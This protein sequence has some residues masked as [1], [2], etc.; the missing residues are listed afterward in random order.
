[1][2]RIL[3]TCVL[4]GA[5]ALAQTTAAGPGGQAAPATQNSKMPVLPPGAPQPVNVP[6]DQLPPDAVVVTIHG[7]CPERTGTGPAVSD[8][9]STKI[10]KEQ[11]NRMLGAINFEGRMLNR[12]TTRSYVENYVQLMV[13]AAVAEEVGVDKDPAFQELMKVVRT[14][15]LAESYRRALHARFKDP[16]PQDFENYYQQNLDKFTRLQIDRV[17]IPRSNPRLP[18]EKQVEFGKNAQK[19][20][21]DIHERAAKGEDV[22][23]LQAEAYKTLG[24]PDAP[25]TDMGPRGKNSFPLALWQQI[26]ALKAGESTKVEAEAAGFGFYRVRSRDVM[27]LASVKDTL[28]SEIAQR[29]ADAALQS[30]LS[31]VHS[32]LNDQFFNAQPVGTPM[33][34][35]P[36]RNPTQP[37]HA[38]SPPPQQPAPPK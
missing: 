16:S 28:A 23:Q 14:R 36:Q 13:L 6:G 34:F 4:V 19:L 33:Q 21:N 18:R 17:F 29:N 1:M 3:L 15:T 10:T 12:V 2:I 20:A 37:G 24:L 38:L 5:T 22:N 31:H 8:S 25:K 35:G 11:I 26:F 9:C 32:E 30:V 27:P 7:L